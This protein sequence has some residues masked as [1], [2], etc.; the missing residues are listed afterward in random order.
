MPCVLN[1]LRDLKRVVDFEFLQFF[2]FSCE[3][4]GDNFQSLYLLDW[5]PELS[6]SL[7]IL[8]M[9]FFDEHSF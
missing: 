6:P 5:E 2:F 7:F 4:R 9:M 1:S 3:D 8:L